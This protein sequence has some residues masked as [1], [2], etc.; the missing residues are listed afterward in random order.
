MPLRS[1]IMK[2]VLIIDDESLAR[3]RL[4]TLL[5]EYCP[6][7]KIVGTADGVETGFQAIH[8]LKPDAVLLDVEMQDG[9][10][11]DLLDKFPSISFHVIFQT[12]FDEFAIKAFQYNAIDYLLKPI[13]ASDLI[14]ALERINAAK[15]KS[16]LHSQ[17]SNLLETTKSEKFDRIVLS[18][19]EGLHFVELN[20]II[21]LES[22]I[23][24]T[25]FHLHST[26]RI[27]VTKTI[28]TFEKLLPKDSFFRNHQSHI[29]NL[30]YV[31]KVLK[32]D[33]GFVLMRDQSKVPIS[34]SKKEP[35]LQ[36]LK[37]AVLKP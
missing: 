18:S 10:G 15:N 24:Y 3:E 32:E 17:L 14:R 26:E 13:V 35:F 2:T 31:D 11:F 27:T 1:I 37:S 25:T 23:N 5:V 33:G 28:K 34:R 19:S 4:E 36:I 12:A 30:K 6:E 8:Q 9:T 7:F 29:V 21:R 22:D 20:D 16:H